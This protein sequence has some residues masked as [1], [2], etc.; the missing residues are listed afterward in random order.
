[1]PL[2]FVSAC[3]PPQMAAHASWT[4]DRFIRLQKI[5]EGFASHVFLAIDTLGRMR[6]ALKVRRSSADARRAA[7]RLCDASPWQCRVSSSQIYQKKN[8]TPALLASVR[9]E[10]SVHGRIV[11]PHVLP[12][13][14]AFEDGGYLCIITW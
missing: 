9:H 2:P 4:V 7:P 10:V 3:C 12:L 8:L 13:L 6:V 5:G 14:A 11:H 1:M